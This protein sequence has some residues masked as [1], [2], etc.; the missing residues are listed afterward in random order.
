MI[1]LLILYALAVWRLS[2]L[3]SYEEGPFGIFDKI[4]VLV[5]VKYDDM[6]NPYGENVISKGILC[7]WCNSVWFAVIITAMDY[8]IRS[9]TIILM[10]PLAI[11]SLVILL[12]GVTNVNK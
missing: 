4:R 11:S 10:F 6:S 3:F 8:Y 7:N 1:E 2:S 12:D 5:G 9:F